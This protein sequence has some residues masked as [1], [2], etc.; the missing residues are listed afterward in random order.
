MPSFL[1]EFASSI[2]SR[3]E[4][5]RERI[6]KGKPNP[7]RDRFK[8]HF[9]SLWIPIRETGE[10][11]LSPSE[12]A[13]IAV[14]SSVYT[15]LLSTGGIFYVIRSLAVCRG[16][17]WKRLETDVFFTK[18]DFSGVHDFIGR[19]MELL[20]F[21]VAIDSLK[22][23]FKCDAVM[24]DGSLYG[25][26][27]H[28]PLEEKIEGE[29]DLLLHYFQTYLELLDLCRRR[30]ILLIGVSKESRST[31][32]RDYILRLIFDEELGKVDIDPD[33]LEKL[34]K[35]FPEVLDNEKAAFDKFEKL[36]EKH[37][38]KM[39]AIELV[40][41]ELASSR[42]DYQL[43]INFAETLGYTQPLI[44]GPSARMAR[45]MKQY[46]SN[47]RRYV[48]NNFPRAVRRKG[49][50]F[51]SW[52][53]GI[54]SNIPRLPGF[55]SFYILLDQ[56]DSP[57]RID[58]P[59][60]EQPLPEITWPKPVNLDLKALLRIMITGY[61]GLDRYNLWLADVDEKVRIRR[62]IVDEIYFPYLEKLF[63]SKIIRGRGYRRVKYP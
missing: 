35:I 5:M 42:P 60:W 30:N 28:L 57:I 19:K 8:K 27:M 32:F 39:E 9:N 16:K 25:R 10:F 55:I 2:N 40:L 31:F 26:A 18:K 3:K 6:F 61:C 43:V 44:L 23:G 63:Q 46:L 37:K 53:T 49:D 21:K 11:I 36:K 34:K 15:N 7:L 29:E 62:K 12:L 38:G 45:A 24:L 58:L 22:N 54:L 47:P 14:D 1:D 41:D 33:D 48:E 50:E 17:K 59:Y 4:E 51:I 52:A 56:R 13:I 20:E